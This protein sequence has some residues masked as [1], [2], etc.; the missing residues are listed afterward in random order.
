MIL[1][2]VIGYIVLTACSR[3]VDAWVEVGAKSP[4]G[5]VAFV[6]AVPTYIFAA[7]KVGSLLH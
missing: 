4:A 7:W 1:D 3:F 2:F 5:A 6:I